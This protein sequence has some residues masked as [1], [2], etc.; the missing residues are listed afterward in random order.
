VV[1]LGAGVPRGVGKKGGLHPMCVCIAG[2]NPLC[3]G[4]AYIQIRKFVKPVAIAPPFLTSFVI[5]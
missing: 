3:T 2:D 4:Y 5:I 1:I